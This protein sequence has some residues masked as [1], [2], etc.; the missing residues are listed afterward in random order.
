M[1]ITLNGYRDGDT[2]DARRDTD[3]LN[4]QMHNVYTLMADHDWHTLV[5]LSGRADAPEASVSA[6]IRD[7]RK[8][9]FGGHTIDR[10]YVHAGV[11]EYRMVPPDETPQYAT[12]LD[13]I[14]PPP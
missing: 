12:L 9:K 8:P 7:L 6:R 3:R 13:L 11:W 14:P 4:R 1:S 5:E 2:F 10:R